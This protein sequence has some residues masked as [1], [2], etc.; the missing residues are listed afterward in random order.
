MKRDKADVLSSQRGATVGCTNS[1]CAVRS[2]ANGGF[3]HP[4]YLAVFTKTSAYIVDKL[5][6]NGQPAHV[7]W[8]KHNDGTSIELNDHV[9]NRRTLLSRINLRKTVVLTPPIVRAGIKNIYS[10]GTHPQTERDTRTPRRNAVPRGAMA[11]AE[12]AG[13]LVLQK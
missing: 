4:V 10:N 7:V 13:L 11:R 1:I 9:V 5:D 3:P 8:Y 12:K 2:A 6:R